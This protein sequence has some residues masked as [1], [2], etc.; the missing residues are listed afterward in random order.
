MARPTGQ[1][2]QVAKAVLAWARI[3]LFGAAAAFLGTVISRDGVDG[4]F[5][6]GLLS[7]LLLAFLTAVLARRSRGIAGVG[8]GLAF[9]SAI[10]WIL[11]LS[12]GAG[13]SILVPVAS[14][15][16]TTFFSAWAGYVWLFGMIIVQVVAALLP[17]KWFPAK[18]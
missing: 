11:A 9:S 13:G 6:W 16:F 14:P 2:G 4:P 15:A 10:A 3:A 12:P 17:R 7:S 1:G 8:A 5:P 18:K